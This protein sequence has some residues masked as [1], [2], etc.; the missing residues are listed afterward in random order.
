MPNPVSSDF[1]AAGMS[2]TPSNMVLF[3]VPLTY[4]KGADVAVEAM[5]ILKQRDPQIEIETFGYPVVRR[6]YADLRNKIPQ[7][8][9][10]KPWI[11]HAQMPAVMARA[12]VVVGRFRLGSLGIT[13][14]E[15]MAS[16]R[17]LIVEQEVPLR[18]LTDYYRSSPPVI[19]CA[20]AG[21]IADAVEECLTNEP[22]AREIGIKER[23]WALQYHSPGIVAELYAQEYRELERLSTGHA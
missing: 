14:L 4:L 21:E 15:A 9:I 6:E 12:R 16:G 3:A 20:N 19:S 8:V 7:G 17:P 13:E 5:R 18:G 2:S 1:F 10:R 23:D 22:L 11:P